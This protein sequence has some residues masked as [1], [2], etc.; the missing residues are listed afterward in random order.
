MAGRFLGK[1]TA[2]GCK[3]CTPLPVSPERIGIFSCGF[4]QSVG[5][6]KHIFSDVSSI[7]YFQARPTQ[8]QNGANH[9]GCKSDVITRTFCFVCMVFNGTSARDITKFPKGTNIFE[10]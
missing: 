5:N 4:H 2:G 8:I 7:A 6:H 3:C 1:Q 10:V 9:T